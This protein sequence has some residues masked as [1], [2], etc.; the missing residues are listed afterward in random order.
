M[1][2]HFRIITGKS[3]TLNKYMYT[4][5]LDGECFS[6]DIKV[7]EEVSKKYFYKGNR[8]TILLWNIT[9][10][11]LVGYL[12][13]VYVTDEFVA[14]IRKHKLT[15]KD[16]DDI[17]FSKSFEKETNVYIFSVA[18]YKKYRD[19]ILNAYPTSKFANKTAIEILVGCLMK[20]IN[21]SQRTIKSFIA[22]AVSKDGENFLR[23]LHMNFDSIN[24]GNKI[25]YL[26]L[27]GNK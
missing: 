22:E 19:K 7:S 11:E 12:T 9:K 26:E 6:K 18:I 13:P 3:L 4:W 1:Y 17:H 16:I 2:D 25:F 8:S 10:N 23:S 27:K 14:G 20:N 5:E 15:Y 24:K 21:N